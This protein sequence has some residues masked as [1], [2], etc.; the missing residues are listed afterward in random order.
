VDYTIR[1]IQ[2]KQDGLKSAGTDRLL[3]CAVGVGVLAE[4]GVCCVKGTV[5]V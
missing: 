4:G 5:E 3:V 1:R 2:V